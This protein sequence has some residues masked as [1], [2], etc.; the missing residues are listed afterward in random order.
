MRVEFVL[1]ADQIQ[2]RAI[3]HVIQVPGLARRLFVVANRQHDHVGLPG[4]LD[5]LFD[6][7]AVF[8]RVAGDHFIDMPRAAYSNL[9]AFAVKHLAAITNLLFDPIE[10]S[11]LMFRHAAVSTEQT[12]I[13]IR[14]NHRD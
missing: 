11:H 8:V 12:A 3:A 10:Q 6:L 5:R 4:N 9:A 14:P 2:G 13:S 1:A 7:A